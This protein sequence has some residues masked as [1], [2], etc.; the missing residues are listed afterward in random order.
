MHPLHERRPF[1][2]VMATEPQPRVQWSCAELEVLMILAKQERDAIEDR[3]FDTKA[4]RQ[5]VQ[6]RINELFEKWLEARGR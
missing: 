2:T 6:D 1:P 3:G 4:K 5:E